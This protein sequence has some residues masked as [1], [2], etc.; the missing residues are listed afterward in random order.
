MKPPLCCFSLP[1][2]RRRRLIRAQTI[3]VAEASLSEDSLI[4][5]FEIP[6]DETELRLVANFTATC[7]RTRNTYAP[8]LTN[9]LQPNCDPSS[10][11]G[12]KYAFE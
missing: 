1:V 8:R 4:Y 6:E 3:Q 7:H 2:H 10:Y 11:V 5:D 9:C 12:W